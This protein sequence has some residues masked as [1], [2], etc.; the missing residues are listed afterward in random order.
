MQFNA[1]YIM[2]SV[3]NSKRVFK[4]AVQMSSGSRIKLEIC[5]NFEKINL[6]LVKINF[7]G[8]LPRAHFG[9]FCFHYEIQHFRISNITFAAFRSCYKNIVVLSGIYEVFIQSSYSVNV[10]CLIVI[11]PSCFFRI[12]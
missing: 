12:L 1:A 8:F 4:S 3:T 7:S 5:F 2:S 11:V 6:S 9:Y 10:F